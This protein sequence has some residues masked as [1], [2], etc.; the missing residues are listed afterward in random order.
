MALA[1]QLAAMNHPVYIGIDPG[2]SGAVAVLQGLVVMFHDT[3]VVEVTR[4]THRAGK[5]AQRE[6]LV[7]AMA[8]LLRPYAK[9]GRAAL[10]LAMALPQQN[11]QG[12]LA[13]GRGGGIWEGILGALEI[14]CELVPAAT[15]KREIFRGSGLSMSDKSASRLLA[16]RLFPQCAEELRLV[17]HD[18]R[19]EALL[20]AE[21]LRRRE[22]GC[23]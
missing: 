23:R 13:F 15:W 19:A 11:A 20:L 4:R 1:E 14:G 9:T 5:R 17:K 2:F 3:P 12:T 10:E 8:A 18:G 7:P 6:Y 16:V 22:N 21:W